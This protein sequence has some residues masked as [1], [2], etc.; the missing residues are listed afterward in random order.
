MLVNIKPTEKAELTK[1]NSGLP[2]L[3]E[4]A[5]NAPFNSHDCCLLGS[6]SS[7]APTGAF[8][9]FVPLLRF[10]W[11]GF[12]PLPFL[13]ACANIFTEIGGESLVDSAVCCGWCRCGVVG[14][15]CHPFPTRFWQDLT[16]TVILYILYIVIV[17]K[18]CNLVC[19]WGENAGEMWVSGTGE[20]AHRISASSS[21]RSPEG[22]MGC[23]VLF[24]LCP[25]NAL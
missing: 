25:V 20:S 22:S 21:E 18:S 9:S 4:A 7:S 10:S 13:L 3:S 17:Q 11:F 8:C 1:K 16:S 6:H 5:N 24:H 19:S 2:L 15:G 12:V 14:L 23:P